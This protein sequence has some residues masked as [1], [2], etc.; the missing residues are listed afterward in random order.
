MQQNT[1]NRI[2]RRQYAKNSAQAK[3]GFGQ[4]SF[5]VAFLRIAACLCRL[6]S[7]R[8]LLY[9]KFAH[10]IGQSFYTLLILLTYVVYILY[11]NI[12]L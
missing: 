6:S 12:Y 3:R 1:G 8:R 4:R 5:E 7:V 11:R 10:L 9:L 2:D